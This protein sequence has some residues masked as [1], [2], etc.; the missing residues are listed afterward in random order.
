MYSAQLGLVHPTA[1]GVMYE[2]LSVGQGD[3]ATRHLKKWSGLARSADPARLYVP[4]AK[5]GLE[6]PP[7]SLMYRK[8]KSSHL[9][10]ESLKFALNAA[11]D[12]LPQT[13]TWHYGNRRRASAMAVSCMA[14]S[15]CSSTSSTNGQWP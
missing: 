7:I 8:L 6:L 4:K 5:G 3:P 10:S 2:L 1:T 15:K 14:G 11:S 9:P 13:P 12:T